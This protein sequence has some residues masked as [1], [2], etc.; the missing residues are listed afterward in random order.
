[1]DEQI[2]DTF[3][4]LERQLEEKKKAEIRRAENQRLEEA[5]RIHEAKRKRQERLIYLGLFIFV[6]TVFY[7]AYSYRKEIQNQKDSFSTWIAETSKNFASSNRL[8]E[9]TECKIPE[10][11]AL[12]KC[13]EFRQSESDAKWKGITVGKSKPFGLNKKNP[14]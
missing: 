9:E 1:M 4:K 6:S 13:V 8:D 12:K 10:N 2:F 11:Y 14:N 5:F 7:L 3:K